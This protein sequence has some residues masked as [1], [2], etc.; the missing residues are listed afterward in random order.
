MTKKDFFRLIIKLFGIYSI[1][2][3][4]FSILPSSISMFYGSLLFGILVTSAIIV[5]AVSLFYFLIV[6][7]DLVI[8]LL[9]LDKGFDN[10]RIEIANFNSE[11]IIKLAAIL[12]GGFLLI[13]YIPIFLIAAFQALKIH[14]SNSIDDQ[15]MTFNRHVTN[16]LV[17]GFINTLIGYFLI[18]N[19]KWLSKVLDS[20]DTVN[21]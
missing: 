11:N 1:I 2:F 14:L 8:N 4:L 15:F 20:K 3:S 10:D 18:T 21:S 7:S 13:Q 19:Y 9:K 5:L 17:R 12:L 6:K 16:S